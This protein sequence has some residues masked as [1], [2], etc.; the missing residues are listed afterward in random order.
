MRRLVGFSPWAWYFLVV[1]ALYSFADKL[2]APYYALFPTLRGL[3]TFQASIILSTFSTSLMLLD[4][5][6]GALADFIGRRRVMC[7]GLISWGAGLIGYG[8]LPGFWPMMAMMVVQGFGISMISG[9]ASSWYVDQVKTQGR[10]EE[11][12]RAMGLAGSMVFGISFVAGLAATSLG[13][14]NPQMVY[15]GS[16]VIALL[17]A[18]WV[19]LTWVENWGKRL[20]GMTYWRFTM[21]STRTILTSKAM[22]QV[23]L[24]SASATASFS[25]FL[26]L[27]QSTAVERGIPAA[28]MGLLFSGQMIP[29]ML[30]SWLAGRQT[31]E[32]SARTVAVG[33]GI[34]ALALVGAALFT[35]PV[36]YVAALCLFQFALGLRLTS[37]SILQQDSV[38][39][40]IRASANSALSTVGSLVSVI[41]LTATGWLTEHFGLQVGWWIGTW[42]ALLGCL[43]AGSMIVR[44]HQQGVPATRTE[45]SEG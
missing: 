32:H 18:A 20:K 14:L 43:V 37:L 23:F 1:A 41:S 27:W 3:T 40:T 29:P 22:R 45:Q 17:G 38:P 21:E 42:A 39:D 25:V 16:G 4:Y 28:W 9:T 19:R 26:L 13:G 30:G 10:E 44:T 31:T 15:V 2:F 35:H 24:L 6:T 36:F 5:P 33:L 12:P 8:L 7:I 34:T 11:I